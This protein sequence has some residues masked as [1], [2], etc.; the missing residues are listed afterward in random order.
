MGKIIVGVIVVVAV[1]GFML[2]RTTDDAVV[3]K[4][5]SNTETAMK[6]GDVKEFSMTSFYDEKGK[7]FSLKEIS[8]KKGD[9]VRIKVTNIKGLHDF[10]IDEYGIKKAT[11]LNQEVIIEFTADKVG[12]FEYYCSMPGHRQAGQFGKLIVKE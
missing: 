3:T 7:W 4:S 9:V 6:A 2:T 5:D 10:N 12:E 11:P 1:I 8:V